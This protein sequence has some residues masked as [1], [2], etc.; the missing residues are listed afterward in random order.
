MTNLNNPLWNANP[1]HAETY[2]EYAV[3]QQQTARQLI[4]FIGDISPRIILEPGCGTG[5]YTKLLADKFPDAQIT[6]VDLSP[7]ALQIARRQLPSANINFVK[8]DIEKMTL[9]KYD[10]ITANAVFQWIGDFHGWMT[11]L[12]DSLHP[13]GTTAFSYFSNHT[14]RELDYAVRQVFGDDEKITSQNFHTADELKCHTAQ[15][16]S[17]AIETADFIINFPTLRDL[18]VSI[19]ATGTR[20]RKENAPVWTKGKYNMVEKIYNNQFGGIK[21]TYNVIF[22]RG[23]K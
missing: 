18:L 23:V 15:F 9:G 6:G 10:L 2:D 3:P 11:R 21:V 12:Y 19:R 13:G 22:F 16:A 20:G 14:Y 8:N 4:N 5:Q 17:S 7:A 1:N